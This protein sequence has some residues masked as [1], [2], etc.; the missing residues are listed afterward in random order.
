MLCYGGIRGGM[1]AVH[2]A[3]G[4]RGEEGM[5]VVEWRWGRFGGRGVK[6]LLGQNALSLPTSYL[7]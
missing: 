1:R 4:R 5:H 3:G 2:V 7:P 6:M